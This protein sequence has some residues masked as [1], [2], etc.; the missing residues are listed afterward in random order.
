MKYPNGLVIICVGFHAQC[1]SPNQRE[2]M[3]DDKVDKSVGS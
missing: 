3:R 1:E 2:G